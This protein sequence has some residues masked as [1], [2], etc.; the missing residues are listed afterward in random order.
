MPR[1]SCF[2]NIWLDHSRIFDTEYGPPRTNSCTSLRNQRSRM[3]PSPFKMTRSPDFL[4]RRARQLIPDHKDLNNERERGNSRKDMIL[5]ACAN[6]SRPH[7][8]TPL[9]RKVQNLGQEEDRSSPHLRSSRSMFHPHDHNPDNTI[10]S[11]DGE[12]HHSMFEAGEISQQGHSSALHSGPSGQVAEE[13]FMLVPK[14]IVTPEI[15][16]LDNG[17]T[18]L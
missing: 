15:K 14:V 6:T 18:T 5:A 1:W 10:A 13:P 7:T 3:S 11:Y 9:S 2:S 16:A 8:P 4:L 17:V 12:G